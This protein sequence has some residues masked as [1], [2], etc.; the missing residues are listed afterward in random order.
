VAGGQGGGG[1]WL[2]GG[3]LVGVVCSPPS[4]GPPLYRGEGCTLAPPPMHLGRR[5]G[6]GQAGPQNPNLGQPGPGA[7]GAPSLLPLMGFFSEK[8]PLGVFRILII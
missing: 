7:Q 6:L 1:R 5:L 4:L 3:G 8:G 2:G